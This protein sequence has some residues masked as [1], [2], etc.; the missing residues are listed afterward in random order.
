MG[1]KTRRGQVLSAQ[2]FNSMLRNPLYVGRI[3]VSAFGVDARGE[4]EAIVPEELFDQVQQRLRKKA[5][6]SPKRKA[7]PDFPLRRFVNCASCGGA[8]TGG[9]SRGRTKTYPYYH[10]HRCGCVRVRKER[11]EGAFV[12]LLQHLQP[13]PEY[14]KLFRAVV[15]DAWK[16][17]QGGARSLR[18][19]LQAR[20]E[21]INRRLEQLE[22]KFIYANAIDQTTYDRQR[23]KLREELALV[24]LE[25]KEAKVEEIDLEGV[26]AFTEHVVR[27]AARLWIEATLEQKVRL[28]G[29]FFPDGLPFDGQR[30]G[31]ASTCLALKQLE[32]SQSVESGVASPTGF[33]RHCTA[34]C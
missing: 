25:L 5:V 31:T 21:G 9:K 7:H 17:R 27:D 19:G 22:E 18:E 34:F 32:D 8:L 2:T 3:S 1:L 33:A 20:V 14:L 6:C 24:R 10:C 4:F 15:L 23:D 29:V 13:T 11:L 30:F 26:L 12:D 16:D 28:Q